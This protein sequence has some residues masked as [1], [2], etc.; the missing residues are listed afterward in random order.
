M[1][2]SRETHDKNQLFID[3][4]DG[5]I[6]RRVP[7]IPSIQNTFA[8][9]YA[10][11][12][13]LRE[14]FS[15][16]KTIDAIDKFVS[17]FDLD[18][19]SFIASKV[20]QLFKILGSRSFVMGSKGFLQHPD[21]SGMDAE[22]YDD[23]IKDPYKIL[24]DKVI[25][26]IHTQLQLHKEEAAMVKA[27]AFYC[28][29]NNLMTFGRAFSE[30]ALKY[31]LA[32]L[33]PYGGITVAPYDYLAD[34]P[35]SFSGIS[36]DIRRIPDKVEAACEALL[37]LM[38]KKG[39]TKGLMRGTRTDQIF[40]PLHM[41]T[42]MQQKDFERF[43]WPTFK[44]LCN[45]LAENGY[46]AFPFLEDNWTRYLDI[47]MDLPERT[48]L[49]I[50]YTDPKLIK[51]KLG[52]KYVISGGYPTTFLKTGTKHQCIDKVKEILDIFAPGGGYFFAFD[53]A[54]LRLADVNI[55]NLR[56]VLDTVKEYGRY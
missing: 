55:D 47:L 11:Y 53:K 17:E 19:M 20:P 48:H 4:L 38:I 16:N 39:C 35:R 18:C 15:L 46:T 10:E 42:F 31:N 56:A 49:A 51:E 45:G 14:Q 50:E 30:I 44:K 2:I 6:P 26:N 37:P 21:V 25:P 28:Y 23:L 5:K 52:K 1:N 7:R 54:I 22:D 12:S 13:L 34:Q 3:V 40:M 8:L 29:V 36:K 24:V 43:Y 32:T 41:A 27:K 33:T 9:E